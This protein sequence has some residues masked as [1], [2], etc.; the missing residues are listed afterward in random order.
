MKVA[1]M[2]PTFF[3][4]IGY[5]YLMS[6][7]DKF[8]FLDDVEISKQSW[9]TRNYFFINGQPSLLSVPICSPSHATINDALISNPERFL[10][11]FRKTLI[12]SYSK[13]G[14]VAVIEDLL[15]LLNNPPPKRLAD[16]N[17]NIIEYF[18]DAFG[19]KTKTL[20]SSCIN[21]EGTKS[22]KVDRILKHLNAD[23]YI[24]TP[25][26]REY[27]TE[28]GLDKFSCDVRFFDYSGIE[29]LKYKGCDENLCVLDVVMR[30]TVGGVKNVILK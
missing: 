9:Q 15:R 11:K 26:S 12:Q 20:R 27:M 16:I 21:I 1:I 19:L 3:P 5:F 24:A 25:G 7:V 23:E 18:A 6:E 2:Q 29:S 28:Y 17:I 4:W 13:I 30:E 8:V 10:N 14:D 22:D